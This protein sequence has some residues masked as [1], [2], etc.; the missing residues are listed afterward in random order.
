M[1]NPKVKW[2]RENAV[3]DCNLQGS[4]T[5]EHFEMIKKEAGDG[6]AS[7]IHVKDDRG[8]SRLVNI[9]LLQWDDY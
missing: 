3:V 2:Q 9:K 6:E 1:K 7:S 8:I 5:K 4:W